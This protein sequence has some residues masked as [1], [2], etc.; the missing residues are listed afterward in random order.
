LKIGELNYNQKRA[1]LVKYI[2]SKV[3]LKKLLPNS[4]FWMPLSW[5]VKINM[6]SLHNYCN[7]QD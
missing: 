6:L 7:Y 5:K 2:I 1:I 4:S 3:A